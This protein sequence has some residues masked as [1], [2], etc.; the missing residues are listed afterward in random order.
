MQRGVKKG[1][2][3]RVFLRTQES[4]VTRSRTRGETV[5]LCEQQRGHEHHAA[6]WNPD[7]L[8]SVA[9]AS[10]TALVILATRLLGWIDKTRFIC[11]SWL[12][13]NPLQWEGLGCSMHVIQVTQA[14]RYLPEA[15]ATRHAGTQACSHEWP[16]ARNRGRQEHL[17]W[18]TNQN[19]YRYLQTPASRTPTAVTNADSMR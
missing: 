13:A 3:K 6:H 15:I 10:V 7:R 12:D 11:F 16:E 2:S 9:A 19:I 18:K 8:P 14:G 4:L 17:R 5:Y 1:A